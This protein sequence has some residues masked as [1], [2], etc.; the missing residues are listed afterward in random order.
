MGLKHILSNIKRHLSGQNA[1]EEA[2]R[3]LS[4]R[5]LYLC[6]F[7]PPVLYIF[8]IQGVERYLQHTWHEELRHTIIQERQALEEG[9]IK[10][11]DALKKN[12]EHFI[13][14]RQITSLGVKLQ[15]LVRTAHGE[16]L[17]P[18][19][20]LKHRLADK[21]AGAEDQLYK[22]LKKNLIGLQNRRILQQ[23]FQLHVSV[24]IPRN[25]WLANIVLLLYIFSFAGILY[26]S[27]QSRVR[28][29]ENAAR[30]QQQ[31]LESTRQRLEQER[32]Q[33]VQ[34]KEQQK[35]Y[36]QQVDELQHRLQDADSQ[37]RNT[38]EEALSEL[39]ALEQRL[40]ETDAEREAREMEIHELS[41]K[42]DSLESEQQGQGKKKE[43]VQSFYSK[44]FQTLYK[45]L[46][47]H[48]RAVQGFAHLPEDW[49]LKAE[50]VI[51]TLNAD[52]GMVNVKR[53]V[54]SRGDAV[55]LETEFAH[56][57]RI[58]WHRNEAGKTT[59]LAVGSKNTQNKDLKYIEGLEG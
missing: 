45:N 30:R 4:F 8:T 25:T 43:K 27:Y 49:K 18:F 26:L 53:K 40:A 15:V 52:P 22:Q 14:T 23:G 2:V 5:V 16:M 56:K 46:V 20:E 55:A 42:L 12:I 32:D 21:P 13:H 59:I 1:K 39:E 54:F 58:Y 9:E 57:G 31:E 28:A 34:A 10:L 33:L 51:H 29:S 19:Y 38:E 41:E 3:L 6:I 50:E 17:Y 48:D 36:Q 47:F 35:T 11:Q 7:L 37:L 24:N 44:R